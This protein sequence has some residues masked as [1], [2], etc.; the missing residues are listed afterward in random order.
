VHLVSVLLV[1]TFSIVFFSDHSITIKLIE[2]FPQMVLAYYY[3]TQVRYNNEAIFSATLSLLVLTRTIIMIVLSIKKE[4]VTE[5]KQLNKQEEQKLHR[6]YGDLSL[7]Q[8]VWVTVSVPW[9]FGWFYAWNFPLLVYGVNVRKKK[10]EPKLNPK[11][12]APATADMERPAAT[13]SHA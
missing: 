12:I 10:V 9:T 4:A 6:L 11:R 7:G 13:E 8:M 5:F 2:D 3:S 1:G